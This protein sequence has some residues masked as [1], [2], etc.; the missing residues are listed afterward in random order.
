MLVPLSEPINIQPCSVP[1]CAHSYLPHEAEFPKA[2]LILFTL[3]HNK[4]GHQLMG[5]PH[6]KEIAQ[7]EE[8][9]GWRSYSLSKIRYIYFILGWRQVL[10]K[11]TLVMQLSKVNSPAAHEIDFLK[12]LCIKVKYY[13][14]GIHQLIF[15]C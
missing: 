11:V 12:I 8:A 2:E 7:N 10:T 13:F 15:V 6:I 9:T 1:S 14:W 5:K 3:V 4:C